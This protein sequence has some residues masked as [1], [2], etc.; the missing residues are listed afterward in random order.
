MNGTAA[1]RHIAKRYAKAL[2]DVVVTQGEDPHV[3][4]AELKKLAEYT[5][6]SAPFRAVC[7]SPILPLHTK[8]EAIDLV[9]QSL[10]LSAPLHRFLRVLAGHHRLALLAMVSEAYTGICRVHRGEVEAEV[11]TAR[12]LSAKDTRTIAAALS[13]AFGTTVVMRSHV[14]SRLLGGM[15]VRV[16]SREVDATVATKLSRAAERFDRIISAS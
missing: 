12:A 15:K 10:G 8:M 3:S 16:G 7:E 5:K 6:E 1:D 13:S 14:D 4:E 11:T 9:A 2:F